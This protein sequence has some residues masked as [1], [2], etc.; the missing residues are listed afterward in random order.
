MV[1]SFLLGL[2]AIVLGLWICWGFIIALF[3]L[4]TEH[5]DNWWGIWE[6]IAVTPWI[7][8]ILGCLGWLILQLGVFIKEELEN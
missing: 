2:T 6:W 7:A 5:K 3:H 4:Y 1:K 8:I